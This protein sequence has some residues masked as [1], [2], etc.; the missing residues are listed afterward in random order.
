[1]AEPTIVCPKCKTE[2]KLN[3]SLAA[4]L[5]EA[6]R[7]EYEQLLIQKDA[8]FSKREILLRNRE[9]AISKAKESIDDQ[10]AEKLQ[11]ERVRISAEEAKKARIALGVD[12]DQ[13]AK[14]VI[15]LHEVLKEKDTKLAEA[16]QAQADL[17]R[18]QRELDDAKRELELT[19][20]KRVPEF[21]CEFDLKRVA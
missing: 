5:I 10:V 1:M 15:E 17:I 3:E 16:Q 8:D 7:R 12:L 9:A 4:P 11:K 19:I 18:K 14:E 20:E 13:K 21:F 2:I 6:T